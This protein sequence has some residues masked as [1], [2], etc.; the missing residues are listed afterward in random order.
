MGC[1]ETFTDM[2]RREKD[3]VSWDVRRVSSPCMKFIWH[4]YLVLNLNN[5][6]NKTSTETDLSHIDMQALKANIDM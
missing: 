2:A 4:S 5:C 6:V 3:G 1:E